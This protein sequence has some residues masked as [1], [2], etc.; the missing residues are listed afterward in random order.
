M[1]S[2]QESDLERNRVKFIRER[3]TAREFEQECAMTMKRENEGEIWRE[4]RVAFGERARGVKENIE[5][6]RKGM[7][8]ERGRERVRERFSRRKSEN[9]KHP[10][11]REVEGRNESERVEIGN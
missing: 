6:E 9:G 10:T 11:K 3:E 8:S 7:Q 5:R 4:R 2:T 1:E